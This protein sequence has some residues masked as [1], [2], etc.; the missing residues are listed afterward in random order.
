MGMGRSRPE[1]TTRPADLLGALWMLFA[2]AIGEDRQFRECESCG[3]W[4]EVKPTL[5]RTTRQFC[6]EA[7]KSRAHRH[8]KEHA[9]VL[10][11]DGKSVAE[12]AEKLSATQTTV[13]GWLKKNQ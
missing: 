7:C 12:I 6:S 13:E 1:L 3:D 10:F 11:T 2:Q 4:F 9:R 5:T 8:R